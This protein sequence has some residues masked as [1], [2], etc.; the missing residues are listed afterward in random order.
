MDAVGNLYGTTLLDGAYGQ[1][2]VFKLIPSNGEWLYTSLHD[3]TGGSDGS[4]PYGQVTL[5]ANGNLYGTASI[6]GPDNK[7]VVW[8]ITP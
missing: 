6:G 2:N 1:G 3:F 5:D 4:Q 8:E 7:G